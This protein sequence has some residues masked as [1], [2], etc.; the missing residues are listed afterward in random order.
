M[1]CLVVLWFLSTGDM[2]ELVFH[3]PSCESVYQMVERKVA[4]RDIEVIMISE[5]GK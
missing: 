4:G 2:K 5:A 1:K 3:A